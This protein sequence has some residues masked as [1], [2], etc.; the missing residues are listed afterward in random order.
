[1]LPLPSHWSLWSSSHKALWIRSNVRAEKDRDV[2]LKSDCPR[3]I[4][5]HAPL[6]SVA[7]T[8]TSAATIHALDVLV[9]FELCTWDAAY[10]RR[11]EVGLL[12]LD[13][14]C[15]AKLVAIR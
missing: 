12:G 8:A 10:T 9:L 2:Y 4:L 3:Q 13:A 15:A 5:P 1:V 7:G 14:S 11:S 6:R